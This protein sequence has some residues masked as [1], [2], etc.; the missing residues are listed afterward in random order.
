MFY[1]DWQVTKHLNCQICKNKLDSAKTIPCGQ[2]ICES[3]ATRIE[4]TACS[5]DRGEFMCPI[6]SD[7]HQVPPKGFPVNQQLSE[8]LNEKPAE[9]NRGPS[10]QLLKK[11]WQQIDAIVD[12]SQAQLRLSVDQVWD[13]CHN[14]KAKVHLVTEE[15]KSFLDQQNE[16][17]IGEIDAFEKERREVFQ[18]DES[19]LESYQKTINEVKGFRA[20]M[21][22]Y[23]SEFKIDE[24]EINRLIEEAS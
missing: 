3:C 14:M 4:Q 19:F 6:C 2:A 22:A 20:R 1:S 7:V 23:L 10:V 12:E 17:M 11:Y 16:R 18:K 24:S 5:T 15:K 21:T 8:I 9:V 13:H